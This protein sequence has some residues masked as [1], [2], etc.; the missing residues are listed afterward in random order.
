MQLESRCLHRHLSVGDSNGFLVIADRGTLP[1]GSL[2]SGNVGFP[3]KR[4]VP[5]SM[6]VL[7]DGKTF[8]RFLGKQRYNNQEYGCKNLNCK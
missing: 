8:N 6:G 5:Y 1:Y 3:S 7:M 2:S 4:K